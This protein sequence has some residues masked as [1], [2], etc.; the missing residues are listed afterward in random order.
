MSCKS[1]LYTVNNV[2]NEL[3][4]SSQIPFGAIVRRF[5]PSVQ[6]DGSAITLS[7]PGYYKVDCSLTVQ[8]SSA[9]DILAA[10]YA[11]GNLVPGL[12]AAGSATAADNYVNLHMCGL[13]RLQCCDSSTVL[14][15]QLG[16]T[17]V[18]VTIANVACVVEKL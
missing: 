8:A 18:P 16:S 6:L 13:V 9:G 2:F 3:Q 14:I 4:P 11:N 15:L 12:S 1:A 7:S 5:G 17:S 10:M